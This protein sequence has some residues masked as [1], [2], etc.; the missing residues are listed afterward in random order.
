MTKSLVIIDMQTWFFRTEDRSA[1]LPWLLSGINKLVPG[2]VSGNLPVIVVRTMFSSDQ[3]TWDQYMRAHNKAVLIEN[4]P[5]AKDVDGLILPEKVST[6]FKTRH[7]T[8]IRTD[9]E[10]M[11]RHMNITSLVLAGAF[12]DGC[13]GLTAI[14]AWER[15]FQVTIAKDAVV[16]TEEEQGDA[17]LRFL[18]VEFGIEILTHREILNNLS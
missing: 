13:V 6:I 12:V 14:D 3:S 17:M 1:K 16:S 10:K 5:S 9:F 18:N 4:T 2:F 7:S 11:L 8:F 15:D